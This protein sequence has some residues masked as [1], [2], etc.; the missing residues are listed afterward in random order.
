MSTTKPTVTPD[1]QEKVAEKHPILLHMVYNQEGSMCP[2]KMS[3]WTLM[4]V[5]LVVVCCMYA[6]RS[7]GT[8][9]AMKGGAAPVAVRAVA[10]SADEL[11]SELSSF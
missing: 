8:S 9:P 2:F 10:P 6:Y 3:G 7:N 11:L 1:K 5:V 4:F